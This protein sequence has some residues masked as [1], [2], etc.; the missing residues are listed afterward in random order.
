MSWGVV[1]IT[2]VIGFAVSLALFARHREKKEYNNGICK[3]GEKLKAFALDSQGG[4]GWTCD[5]PKCRHYVWT[6][7]IK[8][9]GE[10]K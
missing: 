7:W 9:K 6:S 1:A 4:T 2:L 5:N 8:P 10:E 3:C